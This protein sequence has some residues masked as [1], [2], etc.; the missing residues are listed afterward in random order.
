[1][2]SR[3][4][5]RSS[6]ASSSSTGTGHVIPSTGPAQIFSDREAAHAH[7]RGN[8]VAA[9]ATDMFAAKDF[10]NLTHQQPLAWHG[11]LQISGDTPCRRWKTAR[12]WRR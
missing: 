7:H 10:S 3:Y 1:M 2:V 12:E 4:S 5:F 8:L 11:V 9:M 6:A